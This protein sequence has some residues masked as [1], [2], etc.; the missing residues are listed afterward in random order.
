MVP[1]DAARCRCFFA[2]EP[3]SLLPPVCIF[4][5]QPSAIGIVAGVGWEVRRW[6]ADADADGE[7]DTR[8]RG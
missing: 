3:D 5:F 8:R 6:C 2:V 7:V 4:A 1:S